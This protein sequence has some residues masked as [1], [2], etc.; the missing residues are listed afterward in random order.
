MKVG[1]QEKMKFRHLRRLLGLPLFQVV[2][3]LETI[4]QLTA[5]NAWDGGIG[6]YNN[7]EIADGL[8]WEGD[9]DELISKLLLSK[10]LDQDSYTAI[11]EPCRLVVHDWKE[12]CP[13]W[14]R[15]KI[16]RHLL[17]TK[18]L[19]AVLSDN[20]GQHWTSSDNGGQVRTT[21]DNGAL[22]KPIPSLTKPN[23]TKPNQAICP[24]LSDIGG[25]SQTSPDTASRIDPNF[26][27]ALPAAW[28]ALVSVHREARPNVAAPTLTAH[29]RHSLW[30]A[31]REDGLSVDDLALG[32]RWCLT[33]PRAIGIR[34]RWRGI[35]T[36]LRPEH[37]VGY[38][39]S[40]KA[41]DAWEPP[42]DDDSEERIE[43]ALRRMGDNEVAP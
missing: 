17:Q 12:H 41:P 40:A 38:C 16:Q 6:R 35:D 43:A 13:D 28:E 20:G 24:P 11:G 30:R 26:D 32:F 1:T 36:F 7:Q 2:G 19:G 33:S 14:V 9:A 25:Q 21:A 37:C 27:P 34:S 18:D 15:K 5:A 29:R 8:E 42:C 23:L 22:T 31:L 4:W 3:V 39:E 10:W